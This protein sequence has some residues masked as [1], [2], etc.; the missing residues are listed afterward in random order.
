[1]NMDAGRLRD[2][3]RVLTPATGTDPETP[4]GWVEVGAVR[5]CREFSEKK[6]LF[7][8][9]GLGA[10]TVL[11]TIRRRPLALGD[12]L[13]LGGQAHYVTAIQPVE[14]TYLA[15]TTAQVSVVRC[16]KVNLGREPGLA[17]EAIMT[18][19]YLR[20]EQTEPMYTV[21]QQYVLVTTKAVGLA[22]ND[23]IEIAG[24]V[25]VVRIGHCLDSCK[26]EYE[27]FREVEC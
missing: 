12:L 26:N 18:E 11:F 13:E 22:T 20:Y 7:S 23:L 1:M 14:R 3:V 8:S 2:V 4:K 10:R 17:F 5:A 6:T 16:L 27:I 19:K 21:S 25:Y 15:V 9:V 24:E